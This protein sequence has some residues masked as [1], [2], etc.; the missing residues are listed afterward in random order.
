M[1][2]ILSWITVIIGEVFV[3][4]GIFCDIMAAIGL[5]KFPNFYIRIHAL[6]LGTIGG[7]VLPLIGVALIA[8][9]C[10]F[11]GM[12]KWYITGGSIVAAILILILAPAGSH[13]IA[14]SAYKSRTVFPWPQIVDELAIKYAKETRGEK[15]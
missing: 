9:G 14:R 11:L 3:A 4:I 10:D 12:Y 15:A 13:A 8:C 1:A 2:N 5:F 6:T 7:A